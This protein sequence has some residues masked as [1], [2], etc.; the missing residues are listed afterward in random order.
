MVKGRVLLQIV[1]FNNL[2]TDIVYIFNFLP[3]CERNVA[4]YRFYVSQIL[5]LC[6][7]VIMAFWSLASASF[8]LS[9]L[10][11]HLLEK[12]IGK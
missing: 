9:L 6:A 4:E 12:A 7:L 2:K 1:I 8:E 11:Y 3:I 10:N 5:G